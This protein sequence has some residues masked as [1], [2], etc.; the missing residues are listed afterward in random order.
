MIERQKG[1]LKQKKEELYKFL[2]ELTDLFNLSD[3]KLQ[4]KFFEVLL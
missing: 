2:P 1:E 4:V 3:S